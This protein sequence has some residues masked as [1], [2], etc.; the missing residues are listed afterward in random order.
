M[1]SF[2]RDWSAGSTAIL[3]CGPSLTRAQAEHCRGRARIVA[4]NCAIE[5]APFAAALYACDAR[6]WE[7][8]GAAVPAGVERFTQLPADPSDVAGRR[9]R[10]A[11][12][13]FGLNA[14]PGYR[15]AGLEPRGLRYGFSSGH[16]AINLAA[17]FGARRIV[18]LGFDM[19]PRDGR[20]H[21]HAPHP[22]ARLQP[23]DKYAKHI[24]AMVV[25]ASDCAAAGVEVLNAS[26]DTAL[27]CFRRVNLERALP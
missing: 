10:A 22:W 12:A 20:E 7:H 1:T 27:S 26:A 8:Y 21:F 2:T 5:V 25:L 4:V 24:A 9:Q 23:A 18:L 17:L 6:W 19:Q 14:L 13:Q 15:G 3:A 16:Q 11:V